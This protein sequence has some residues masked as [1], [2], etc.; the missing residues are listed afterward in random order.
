FQAGLASFDVCHDAPYRESL[1]GGIR[2]AFSRVPGWQAATL[3]WRTASPQATPESLMSRHPASFSLACTA[4]LVL[5]GCGDLARLDERD[6]YGPNPTLP[7]PN[8][9]LLPTVNIAPAKGW[10]ANTTPTPA[11]GLVVNAFASGLDH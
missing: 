8:Q 5:A 3:Y 2:I 7:A 6:G 9:T 11:P 4:L 10:P 1:P